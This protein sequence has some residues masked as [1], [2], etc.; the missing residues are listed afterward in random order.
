MVN[1]AHR[2]FDNYYPSGARAYIVAF[3]HYAQH[4][5]EHQLYVYVADEADVKSYLK[6]NQLPPI[7]RK[8]AMAIYR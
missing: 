4:G 1:E 7:V 6:A 2:L 3:R 5:K 8:R